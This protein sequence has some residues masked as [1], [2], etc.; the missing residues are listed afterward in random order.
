MDLIGASI[1]VIILICVVIFGSLRQGKIKDLLSGKIKMEG[2]GHH[3]HHSGSSGHQ[4]H[5]RHRG[6]QGNWG[7]QGHQGHQGH[8]GHQGNWGHR[9][10]QGNWGHTSY[11]GRSSGYYYGDAYDWNGGW[12]R[13]W[14]PYWANWNYWWP[15]SYNCVDYATAQCFGVPDYQSCF[16]A[17]YRNCPYL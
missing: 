1:L 12:N 8:R 10:H 6:H 5:Q 9:G 13:N 3:S 7:H 16:N 11:I 4:G 17:E 15:S 14:W 2:G